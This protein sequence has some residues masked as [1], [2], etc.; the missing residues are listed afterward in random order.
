MNKLL[1][2]WIDSESIN[3]FSL[4]RIF[5][6]SNGA[7]L[8]CLGLR[9]THENHV[10]TLELEKLHKGNTEQLH[11]GVF[12]T[13]PPQDVFGRVSSHRTVSRGVSKAINC[14]IS[15]AEDKKLFLLPH[16]AL[17]AGILAL[18]RQNQCNCLSF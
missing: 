11:T 18:S 8:C 10:L 5:P 6:C 7:G 13:Q 4:W 16:L 12:Q 15:K 2:L 14:K 9:Q 17:F 3:V 1:L